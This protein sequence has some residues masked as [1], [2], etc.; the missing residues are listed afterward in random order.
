VNLLTG[1]LPSHKW[2]VVAGAGFAVRPREQLGIP[3]TASPSVKNNTRCHVVPIVSVPPLLVVQTVRPTS[4]KQV[5]ILSCVPS[6][7]K[8]V[9]DGVLEQGVVTTGHALGVSRENHRGHGM[10]MDNAP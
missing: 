6:S 4:V 5:S 7:S 10:A 9:N 1:T 2:I 3:W 8:D